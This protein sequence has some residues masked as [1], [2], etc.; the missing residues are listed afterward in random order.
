V[1][2]Q[3]PPSWATEVGYVSVAAGVRHAPV[4]DPG[5]RFGAS[6]GGGVFALRASLRV[7]R[8][9]WLA[10]PLALVYDAEREGRLNWF[11]WAGV[12]T[13]S[14]TNEGRDGL[15]LRGF[16]ALGADVRFRQS[17][18]HSFNASLAELG[19]FVWTENGSYCPTGAS[20]CAEPVDH[21]A[22]PD[23]WLTQ[24][25]LGLSETIPGAVTFNAGAS[26]GVNLLVK[27]SV[28]SASVADPERNLVLAFGSVQRAGLRPL[29]LIHVPI[30][31]AW[32]VDA[33]VVVAYVPA[34][35]GWV[36]TYMGGFSYEH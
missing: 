30:T 15:V 36:E 14:G 31:Q 5:F 16:T 26:A 34:T 3:Q 21:R 6:D 18:R 13:I 19:S 27:G 2:D 1:L 20:A 33:H 10:A 28:S 17:A 4:I 12:P 22:P 29:P 23:T 8:R 24:L 9:L 7:A 25:T 32:S 11:A 35:Q